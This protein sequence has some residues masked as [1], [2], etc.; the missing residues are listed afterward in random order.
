MPDAEATLKFAIRDAIAMTAADTGL[1]AGA[2][3]EKL[4][5][6]VFQSIT[7]K[8]TAWAIKELTS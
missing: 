1:R 7:D 3:S 6:A 5:D 4:V 8:A 2:A